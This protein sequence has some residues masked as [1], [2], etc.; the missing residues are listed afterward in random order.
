MR[1]PFADIQSMRVSVSDVSRLRVGVRGIVRDAV[2]GSADPR[3]PGLALTEPIRGFMEQDG[4]SE[5]ARRHPAHHADV[6]VP[7]EPPNA[8]PAH[9]AGDRTIVSLVYIRYHYVVDVV[10]GFG[11]AIL[12]YG[13]AKGVDARIRPLFT[14]ADV[15]ARV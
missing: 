1:K 6:R 4:V 12:N 15:G 11:M 7:P 8:L 10:V 14:A 3:L 5:P 2:R 13:L 9:G